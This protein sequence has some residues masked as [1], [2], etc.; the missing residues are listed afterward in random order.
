MSQ[1][2]LTQPD[3]EDSYIEESADEPDP[4]IILGLCCIN[5]Y[6]QE[7]FKIRARVVQRARYTV[8][9]GI[10]KARQ[11]LQDLSRIMDENIR[12]NIKSFRMSSELLPR[13]TDQDVESYDMAQFQD[14]FEEI[15]TKA[16]RNNIR[17]TFH[18]A[19]FTVL[20]SDNEK[21]I[22]NSINEIEYHCEM[23]ERM[24]VPRSLGVCNIHVGGIYEPKYKKADTLEYRC[25]T[26]QECKD[27]VIERWCRNHS[28][29]SDRSKGYLTIENDEKM[30]NLDDCLRISELCGVP[31]VY[32]T[33]HEECY[34]LLHPDEP[35][36]PVEDNL[37]RLLDSWKR[38]ERFPMA[39]I[40]NQDTGKR[41]GAHSEFITRV[42]DIVYTYARRCPNRTLWLDVEAKAKEEA[43]FG[44]RKNFK[45]M[46]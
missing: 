20:A 17:L 7:S 19:Q 26:R 11:N 8:E 18:P 40:S 12:Q 31:V 32:D 24:G 41:V 43:V 35:H 42:P 37:D 33:H 39:H 29:L 2:L 28:R 21:I 3:Q 15:G 5:N 44:M 38:V 6:L 46:C 9:I 23:L 1:I 14:L 34:I 22:Q 45:C 25:R 13:Y 4:T 36:I 16:I 30:F 10:E 27:R